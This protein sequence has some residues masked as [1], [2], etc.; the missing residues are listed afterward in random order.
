MNEFEKLMKREGMEKMLE[1]PKGVYIAR[2]RLYDEKDP[3]L[4]EKFETKEEMDFWYQ[5]FG[6]WLEQ[7]EGGS[8]EF[9]EGS[10]DSNN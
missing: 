7:E 4:I 8:V 9:D 2:F 3:I 1:S 10:P 6:R 5:T